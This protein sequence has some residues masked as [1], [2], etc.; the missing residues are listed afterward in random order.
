VG[1]S[2]E[3]VRLGGWC[4][5]TQGDEMRGVDGGG[6]DAAASSALTAFELKYH[7][8]G[9]QLHR[10]VLPGSAD[11]GGGRGTTGGED[12]EAAAVAA[13]A[14]EASAAW[15]GSRREGLLGCTSTTSRMVVQRRRAEAVGH[16]RGHG[17][18]GGSPAM[19]VVTMM[20]DEGGVAGEDHAKDL[21][22]QL[23]A[24]QAAS[25]VAESK[26]TELEEELEA[27]KWMY[28]IAEGDGDGNDGTPPQ[29][30]DEG[31]EVL[32][33]EL[34]A[35][36]MRAA[37]AELQAADASDELDAIRELSELQA[38]SHRAEVG[39]LL[40]RLGEAERE[41]AAL[42][43]GAAGED[44]MAMAGREADQAVIV[45]LKAQVAELVAAL[46]GLQSAAAELMQ[47]RPKVAMLERKL[48]QTTAAAGPAA[49][50]VKS[51]GED[52]EP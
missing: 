38:A 52:D 9:E 18:R 41:V 33:E 44:G 1:S 21:R 39:E 30:G 40:S 35:E 24:A 14:A 22:T 43:L 49:R 5:D 13:V 6:D 29:E 36:R 10:L 51:D 42:R 20:G 25:E 26:V 50:P 11:D 47:L 15:S 27:L 23:A 12:V 45:E 3:A 32:A 16:G 2:V 34:A 19:L 17:R 7:R 46:E 4:R 8:A 28:G 48:E 37:R 31:G